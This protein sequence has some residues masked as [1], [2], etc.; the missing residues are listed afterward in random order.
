MNMRT[1]VARQA[2]NFE[3]EYLNCLCCGDDVTHPICPHCITESFIQW[4]EKFPNDFKSIKLKLDGFLMGHSKLDHISKNCV[5]CRKDRTHICPK[6]FTEYLYSL[7]KEAGL[8]VRAMSE[9]LFIFNFDFE[10]KSYA[11]DLEI[12]GG[13]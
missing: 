2:L 3:K 1:D 9:F 8:G 7:V 6:C 10:R 4:L 5:S 11:K 13:Y 12:L